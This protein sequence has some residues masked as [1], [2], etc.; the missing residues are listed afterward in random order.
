MKNLPDKVLVTGGAGFIGSHL[1][2]HLIDQGIEVSVLDNFINGKKENLDACIKSDKLKIFEG[3]ILNEDMCEKAIQDCKVVFHLA[4]LGVRH[5]LHDPLKNHEV[6][7]TA[8]LKVL[9]ASKKANVKRFVYI[10]TSEVYGLVKKFPIDEEVA[11]W[12][13]TV[14]GASKLAGEHYTKA[15][16]EA[17]GLNT[18]CVRPFNNYGPRAHFEGD[19]GEVIP[20][21]ILKCLNNQPPVIFGNGEQTRDFLYVKDCAKALLNIAQE[22]S[23]RKNVVNLG[24]GKEL[25]I[26]DLGKL[27]ISITQ[28]KVEPRFLPPRPADV[29]RLWVNTEKLKKHI[30]FEPE[31][32]F[33]KG[34]TETVN[35]YTKLLKQNPSLL[36]Q[37]KEKNWEV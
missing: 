31:T 33:E 36:I 7:A 20:R 11:T 35:Y 23:L 34:L 24:Y 3:D 1:V 8:T 12:P 28:S 5:S 13:L 27:I 37:L 25:S 22:N 30:P 15:Y 10:S 16:D 26:L 32:S 17:F 4:C 14:Y 2:E 21:F 18:I 29:P 19:A 6:N 9:E